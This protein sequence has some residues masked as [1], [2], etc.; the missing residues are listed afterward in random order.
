M[1]SFDKINGKDTE[2]RLVFGNGRHIDIFLI[3]GTLT[4]NFE[5]IISSI[6]TMSGVIG[7]N[8]DKFIY[9]LLSNYQNCDSNENRYKFLHVYLRTIVNYADFFVENNGVDYAEFADESKKGDSGV[10][11]DENE[12]KKIIKFSEALKIYTLFSNTETRLSDEYHK[13]IYYDI[14]SNLDANSS[15]S[16]ILE[17]LKVLG[18]KSN[19]TQWQYY[20]NLS[21]YS[22]SKVMEAFNIITNI[23]IIVCKY[24]RNPI[25]FFIEIFNNIAQWRDPYKEDGI[26]YEDDESQNDKDDK[27]LFDER[28]H[29]LNKIAYRYDLSK[30]EQI[31]DSFLVDSYGYQTKKMTSKIGD[32]LL[33]KRL[34]QIK[35][36]S[37]FWDFIIAPIFSKATGI[38]YSFLR[39]QSP[40]RVA[41]MSFYL[42]HL[43]N[44]LLNNK[45]LYLFNL[46]AYYPESEIPEST[47]YRLNNISH[48][49]NST[50]NIS[51]DDLIHIGGSRI[52]L[53]RIIEDFIGKMRIRT[54]KYC[55]ILTGQAMDGINFKLIEVKTIDY[56]IRYFSN[57]FETEIQGLK[58]AIS[59]DIKILRYKT[60][61][62]KKTKDKFNKSHLDKTNN[63]KASHVSS[64]SNGMPEREKNNAVE[65]GNMLDS[66]KNY[67]KTIPKKPK[68]I[69]RIIDA[70]TIPERTEYFTKVSSYPLRDL[71]GI[72]DSYKAQLSDHPDMN[73]DVLNYFNE[74]NFRTDFTLYEQNKEV[75][76]NLL[77][78]FNEN[79]IESEAFHDAFF[80]FNCIEFGKLISDYYNNKI[81]GQYQTIVKDLINDLEK[82]PTFF[83][84]C[85]MLVK[86][87]QYCKY[88]IIGINRLLKLIEIT[89][90]SQDSDPIE[91]YL[92]KYNIYLNYDDEINMGDFL[93][94]IDLAIFM[95]K[96]VENNLTISF[97]E[98]Y[99][100]YNQWRSHE[101]LL[102]YNIKEGKNLSIYDMSDNR[103]HKKLP[104][105]TIRIS[106]K[107]IKKRAKR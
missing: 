8:F 18:L 43:L 31:S 85:K 96:C 16:K 100:V 23:Q 37:P 55:N 95:S 93:K 74:L 58:E 26:G 61:R 60:D 102:L 70:F 106:T 20:D 63:N 50:L 92:S 72:I 75:Y 79:I 84:R 36:I 41:V 29:I 47:T 64:F 86:N 97:E 15:V 21:H 32:I 27:F 22:S 69:H 56:L 99:R 24:D 14:L 5:I 54:V 65:K 94:K 81:E 59:K 19:K 105:D 104:D 98:I 12:I 78:S 66:S 10:F 6:Q 42:A 9:C 51:R 33:R 101:Q 44:P 30:V 34:K 62:L 28:I 7:E 107:E 80:A 103:P 4:N 11:F 83:K 45:F 40:K 13:K 35:Y 57:N 82:K 91:N 53:V 25:P 76:S 39:K 89:K 49:I 71:T 73:K 87:E 52:K 17:L 1:I 3:T 2:Y 88:Y 48:L 77:K 46:A 68:E 90:N 67:R 38:R